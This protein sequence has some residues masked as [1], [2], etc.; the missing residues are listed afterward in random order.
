MSASRFRP[1]GPI[2]RAAGNLATRLSDVRASND[3]A[4]GMIVMH[5][6]LTNPGP[7][8]RFN[9]RRR[10]QR[11]CDPKEW[12]HQECSDWMRAHMPGVEHLIMTTRRVYRGAA[13]PAA[14]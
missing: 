4:A 6:V 2:G 12:G 9:R 7:R 11:F 10:S 13:G 5:M 3:L 14:Q 8:R 1:A